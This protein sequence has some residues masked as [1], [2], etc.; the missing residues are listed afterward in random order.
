MRIALLSLALVI[1]CNTTEHKTSKTNAAAGAVV[2]ST[3]AAKAATVVT[4]DT[5]TA[6][7]KSN[8][9]HRSSKPRPSVPTLSDGAETS[10]RRLDPIPTTVRALYV[11]RWAT[12]SRRRMAK[13]VAAADETEINALVLDM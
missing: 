1:A 6:Q 5:G 11:N 9:A 8:S 3:H 10:A 12:Q 2:D 13:L 4:N 7:G